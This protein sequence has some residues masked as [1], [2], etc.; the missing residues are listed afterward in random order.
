M[1]QKLSWRTKCLVHV[2]TL[3]EFL[4]KQM[5]HTNKYCILGIGR[6][7][8]LTRITF[9]DVVREKTFTG[10]PILCLPDSQL[11]KICD[12]VVANPELRRLQYSSTDCDRLMLWLIHILS[13]PSSVATLA[14]S[15]ACPDHVF[16]FLPPQIIT[17]KVDWPC[18]TIPRWPR[19]WP[20]LIISYL[21][22]HHHWINPRNIF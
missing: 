20:F 9:N 13:K 15:L 11:H 17:E 7:R 18:K 2:V 5:I 1:L 14:R 12:I 21:V 22:V 16:H 6:R 10:S 3:P 8:K 4:H 19:R